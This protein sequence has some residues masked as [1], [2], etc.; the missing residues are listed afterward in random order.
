MDLAAFRA[1][2]RDVEDLGTELE[3]MD[4]EG[5]PGR[6]YLYEGGP[7]IQRWDDG[8]NGI[9]PP[10]GPT[11]LLTLEN[12]QHDGDLDKLE[13]LLFDWCGASAYFD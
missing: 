8:R 11:W 2:G 1:T 13:A 3:G 9:A 10:N 4:L 12:E 5:Q 7:W 6:V